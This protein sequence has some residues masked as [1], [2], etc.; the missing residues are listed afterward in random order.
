MHSNSARLGGEAH[1]VDVGEVLVEVGRQ[2]PL[3]ARRVARL[4]RANQR[5]RVVSHQANRAHVPVVCAR[6]LRR[7][8]DRGEPVR[9]SAQQQDGLPQRLG[10]LD[11]RRVVRYVRHALA[12]A[13]RLLE[14]RS[15]LALVPV[16]RALGCVAASASGED[17]A[18]H[19][20]GGPSDQ[21][22]PEG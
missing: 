19:P 14:G 9:A 20:R 17:K 6:D 22:V 21:H 5:G 10:L 1:R 2:Q 13:P 16:L 15:E 3:D 4:G 18:E 11:D 7:R 12:V 8:L